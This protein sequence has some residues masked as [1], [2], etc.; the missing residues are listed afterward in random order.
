MEEE[1]GHAEPRFWQAVHENALS[2]WGSAR[3]ARLLMLCRMY[4]RV[5]MSGSAA[6]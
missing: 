5:A 6:W 4:G 1:V 3:Y 2:T